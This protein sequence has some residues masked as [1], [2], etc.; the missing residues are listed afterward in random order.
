MKYIFVLFFF[1]ILF[2][3]FGCLVEKSLVDIVK[4]MLIIYFIMLMDSERDMFRKLVV[5]FEKEYRDFCVSFYF[6][7][8]DYENM[9]CVRM[10]VNDLFDFFDIYGWGKIR[11]GEYIVDFR[12]MGW[13]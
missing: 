4:K 9:M 6:S 3:L 12:D 13:I 1:F 8:N 5:V 7:G 2:V 10:V 11:Y